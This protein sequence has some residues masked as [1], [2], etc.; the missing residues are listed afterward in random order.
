MI[1]ILKYLFLG[2]EVYFKEAPP[3]RLRGNPFFSKETIREKA[4]QSLEKHWRVDVLID[5][6]R[7]IRNAANSTTSWVS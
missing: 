7:S 1:E 2:E 6:L 4:K 3:R 5:N